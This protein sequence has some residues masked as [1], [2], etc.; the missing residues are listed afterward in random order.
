MSGV[1]GSIGPAPRRSRVSRFLQRWHSLI[2][3]SLVGVAFVASCST[4][5]NLGRT[6]G[7]RAISLGSVA[8][9]CAVTAAVLAHRELKR[10]RRIDTKVVV[11]WTWRPATVEPYQAIVFIQGILYPKSL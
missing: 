6:H 8:L 3:S 4:L 7:A 5:A 9:S 10:N 11:D 1:G 2:H